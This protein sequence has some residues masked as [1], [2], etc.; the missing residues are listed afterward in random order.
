MFQYCSLKRR[1]PND[2]DRVDEAPLEECAANNAK[3]V[4]LANVP[5]DEFGNAE[6]VFCCPMITP[7]IGFRF[8]YQP[9]GSVIAKH[10]V[11]PENF[12]WVP[13]VAWVNT[14]GQTKSGHTILV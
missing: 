5:V 9:Q 7:T 11:D 6:L 12:N 1:P 3:G 13:L 4:L 2:I 10:T 8:T 14:A